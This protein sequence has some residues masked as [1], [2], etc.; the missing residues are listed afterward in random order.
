[1]LWM[2]NRL[3]AKGCLGS[4]ACVVEEGCEFWACLVLALTSHTS[5]GASLWL[6]STIL[7]A[8]AA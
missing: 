5:I 4:G 2:T 6:F 3:P 8:A 1:M 7:Q